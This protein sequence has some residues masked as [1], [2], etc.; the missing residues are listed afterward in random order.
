MVYGHDYREKLI[1][2]KRPDKKK[3]SKKSKQPKLIKKLKKPVE[4]Q[5]EF[6]FRKKSR[7]VSTLNSYTVRKFKWWLLLVLL[8][9]LCNKIDHHFSLFEET[10]RHIEHAIARHQSNTTK[11]AFSDMV[12]LTLQTYQGLVKKLCPVDENSGTKLLASCFR[13]LH[14]KNA[15]NNFGRIV[16]GI[17]NF[18]SFRVVRE[19]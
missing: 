3:K 6:T 4:I 7:Q 18:L 2:T 17:F 16:K 19:K 8:S 5:E 13:F 11:S 14:L 1:T 12:Y 9:C 15:I 10:L